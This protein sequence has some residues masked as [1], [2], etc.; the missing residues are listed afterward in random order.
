MDEKKANTEITNSLKAEG[1]WAYKIPDMPSS[2]MMMGSFNPEK[3]CD[4]IGCFS[5]KF[6]A[7]ETKLIKTKK[8][9]SIS[10]FQDSQIKHLDQ[11]V[12]SGNGAAYAFIVWR[13][14]QP[15]VNK[16]FILNWAKW[17]R[18]LEEKSIPGKILDQLPYVQGAKK[19]YDLKEFVKC[20][21]LNLAYGFSPES[22]ECDLINFRGKKRRNG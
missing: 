15:R 11:I 12:E 13:Q 21:E 2:L 3:P 10:L 16:L 19:L 7:I 18:K 20:V 22:I 8:A 17:G 9:I 1:G 6:L 4:I 5:G 14:P